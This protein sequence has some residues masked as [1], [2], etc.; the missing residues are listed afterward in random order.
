MLV[1]SVKYRFWASAD[2]A[3]VSESILS[4]VCRRGLLRC[5]YNWLGLGLCAKY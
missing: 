5:R 1:T 3:P 4:C 2:S